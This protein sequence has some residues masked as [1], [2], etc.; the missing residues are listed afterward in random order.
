MG[1]GFAAAGRAAV[2]AVAALLSLL[3]AAGGAGAA[4]VAERPAQARVEQSVPVEDLAA[5]RQQAGH[6][7]AAPRIPTARPPATRPERHGAPAA[8]RH[9]AVPPAPATGPGPRSRPGRLTVAL[10]VFRC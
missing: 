6:R 5:E 7:S 3:L 4:L 9:R 8:R 10:Q 1:Y 2:A